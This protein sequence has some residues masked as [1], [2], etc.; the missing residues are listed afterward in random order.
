MTAMLNWVQQL[1]V[2]WMTAVVLIAL[3]I[4]AAIIHAIVFSLNWETGGGVQRRVRRPAAAAR[5][6]LRLNHRL[7]RGGSVGL[8]RTPTE[9][10]VTVLPNRPFMVIPEVSSSDGHICPSLGLNRRQ[11]RATSCWSLLTLNYTTLR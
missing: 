5:H 11:F 10:H 6:H 9:Y 2:L 8:A 3:L 1:P 4:V 7:R